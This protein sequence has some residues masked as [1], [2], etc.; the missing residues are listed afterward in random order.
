MYFC[1][2]QKGERKRY[3]LSQPT[4]TQC[5]TAPVF[6]FETFCFPLL[7]VQ[8]IPKPI[9][10]MRIYGQQADPNENSSNYYKIQKE[11]KV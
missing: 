2:H 10:D 5:I 7:G 9:P 1:F 6:S 3:H 8:R 11:E 4:W